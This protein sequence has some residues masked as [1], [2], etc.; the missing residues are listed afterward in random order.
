MIG[1]IFKT[2]FGSSGEGKSS[3]KSTVV[4]YDSFRI[5]AAPMSTNGQWQ[6]AG[7]IE[8]TFGEETKVH[9]FIRADTMPAEA[10]AANE[11]V[12]KAKMMIDQQ[13]DTIFD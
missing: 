3:K 12:R 1:K 6:V 4:E 8:K 10:D 13:G 7:R 5:I 9:Q 2:L 11:M